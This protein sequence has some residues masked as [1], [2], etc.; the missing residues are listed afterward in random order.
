FQTVG[1]LVFSAVFFGLALFFSL[2]ENKIVNNIGKLLNPVFLVLLAGVFFLA[3]SSPMGHTGV[4]HATA[5][6]T[7][8]SFVNGFLQGYNTMDA[9]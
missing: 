5:A 6:Y 7:S 4:Q 2:E 3:F 9:L 8:G 1:L